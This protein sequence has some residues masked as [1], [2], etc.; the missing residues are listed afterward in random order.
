MFPTE[1]NFSKTFGIQWKNH[2]GICGGNHGDAEFRSDYKN[3][4]SLHHSI[5]SYMKYY[6]G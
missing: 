6:K 3:K 5:P 1:L 4:S 2:I